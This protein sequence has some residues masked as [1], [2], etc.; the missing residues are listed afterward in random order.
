MIKKDKIFLLLFPSLF[1]MSALERKKPFVVK[2]KA[3]DRKS[4]II[5]RLN[6]ILLSLPCTTIVDCYDG[7]K[8]KKD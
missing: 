2:R 5:G 6:R 4:N 7:I 1:L 8:K 3:T